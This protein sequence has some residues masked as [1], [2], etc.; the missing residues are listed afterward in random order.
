MQQRLWG[1]PLSECQTRASCMHSPLGLPEGITFIH[2]P[3]GFTSRPL[4]PM[5][6]R[7]LH[8]QLTTAKNSLEASQAFLAKYP[9]VQVA[10]SFWQM[11]P[12][13]SRVFQSVSRLLQTTSKLFTPRVQIPISFLRLELREPGSEVPLPLKRIYLCT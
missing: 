9:G 11:V 10:P 7:L 12:T 4:L 6:P 13:T 8:Y 3:S 1:S 2:Q 5:F